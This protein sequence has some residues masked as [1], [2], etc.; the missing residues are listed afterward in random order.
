VL[1]TGLISECPALLPLFRDAFNE[2]YEDR[3][4]S[5]QQRAALLGLGA[6]GSDGSIPIK[7]NNRATTDQ[8]GRGQDG[9]RS[10]TLV[11][12]K[13]LSISEEN[14]RSAPGGLS[15]GKFRTE[16]PLYRGKGAV[17]AGQSPQLIRCG[18]GRM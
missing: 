4:R 15:K 3:A 14:R 17:P 10:G 7:Q 8:T 9:R 6:M 16:S 12:F 18:S 13:N 11:N 5:A 1:H 2:V